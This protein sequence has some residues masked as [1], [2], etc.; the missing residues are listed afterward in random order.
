MI[1]GFSE[2]RI[3]LS[4]TLIFSV[5]V[6]IIPQSLRQIDLS[7]KLQIT[8]GLGYNKP[9][10]LKPIYYV[11]A[12]IIVILPTLVYIIRGSRNLAIALDTRGFRAYKRR[13][14]L[15]KVGINKFNYI[16]LFFSALLLYLSFQYF[17]IW[18]N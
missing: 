16:L 10:L 12:L 17:F 1:R 15:A 5:F 7:Y 13:T 6:K 9:L 14:S 4:I 2:L 3:P 8:R 11:Y 18:Q